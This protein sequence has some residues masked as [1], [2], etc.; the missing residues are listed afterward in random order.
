MWVGEIDVTDGDQLEAYWAAGKE[1]DTYGRPYATARSL[2]VMKVALRESNAFS[3]I[4]PLAAMDGGEVLGVGEVVM[5]RLDNTHVAYIEISVR[6][7]HRKRGIGSAIHETVLET[8]RSRGRTTIIAEA[9]T[10]F[11]S[12]PKSDG[13]E[14]LA[15]RGYSVASLDIHRVLD[16]PSEG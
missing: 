9:H 15:A 4:V 10:P 11:Q 2:E 13:S 8:V 1:G 12:P 7:G 16:L 14:F 5:P 6:P 3:E